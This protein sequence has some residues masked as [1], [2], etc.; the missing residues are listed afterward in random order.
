MSQD[1]DHNSVNVGLK[2]RKLLKQMA[3]AG[4]GLAMLPGGS[5]FAASRRD[6]PPAVPWVSMRGNRQNTG[7]SPLVSFR[8]TPS[9]GA[10]ILAAA[11]T[12]IGMVSA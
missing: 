8:F 3:G 9:G 10:P 7:V 11:L 12:L 5:T 6:Y 1:I 2:R 4:A